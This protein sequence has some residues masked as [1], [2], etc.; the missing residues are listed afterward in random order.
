MIR[1]ANNIKSKGP[2]ILLYETLNV[3]NKDWETKSPHTTFCDIVLQKI[4]VPGAKP[5]LTEVV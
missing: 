2:N 4:H 1:D 5:N 3:K